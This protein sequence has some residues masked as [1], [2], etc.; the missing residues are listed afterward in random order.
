[1]GKRHKETRGQGGKGDKGDKG[2]KGGKGDRETRETRRQGRKFNHAISQI[3]LDALL[4][5]RLTQ[6]ATKL[7]ETGTEN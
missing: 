5:N 7:K 1:M 6:L 3:N 2:G 4:G